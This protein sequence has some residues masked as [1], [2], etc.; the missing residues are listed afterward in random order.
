MST[1]RH[2]VKGRPVSKVNAALEQ[3]IIDKAMKEPDFLAQLL[4]DPLGCLKALASL[5][6]HLVRS[7][8]WVRC[9]AA[10]FSQG[11]RVGLKLPH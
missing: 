2:F 6:P 9:G 11:S 4:R 8:R 10:A 1:V 5:S 7:R 3:A